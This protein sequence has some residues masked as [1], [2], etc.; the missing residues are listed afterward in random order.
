[1]QRPIDQ[2]MGFLKELAASMQQRPWGPN[3]T[4]VHRA[5]KICNKPKML[6]FCGA[7]IVC[8]YDSSIT[9]CEMSRPLDSLLA[10][11]ISASASMRK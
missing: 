9:T 4:L 11:C 2:E 1:M 6:K 8:S 5:A 3:L 7:A 10:D